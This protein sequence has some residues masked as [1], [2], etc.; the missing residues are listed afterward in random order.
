MSDD[1]ILL[2]IYLFIYLFICNIDTAN[3]YTPTYVVRII[4]DELASSRWS[5]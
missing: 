1:D 3:L 2:F 5:N 4:R